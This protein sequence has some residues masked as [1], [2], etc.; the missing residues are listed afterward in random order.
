MST[1]HETTSLIRSLSVPD[2]LLE[3]QER[4]DAAHHVLTHKHMR[5][6]ALAI[7]GSY[8][9]HDDDTIR[10]YTERV[11]RELWSRFL[12]GAGLWDLMSSQERDR[13]RKVVGSEA[14]DPVEPFSAE[15]AL[16]VFQDLRERK[17]ELRKEA[18]AGLYRRLSWDHKT[19]QPAQF[20]EKLIY[21]G[22]WDWRGWE[23]SY[24]RDAMSDLMRELYRVDG[25]PEP[26]THWERAIDGYIDVQKFKNGNAHIRLLR[27]D[28]VDRLNAELGQW[29]PGALPAPSRAHGRGRKSEPRRH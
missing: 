9:I 6:F 14:R 1:T 15:T 18:L 13:W 5:D 16:G 24:G 2:L 4:L 28:L 21:Q 23:T 11:D 27:P 20:G 29:F 7:S 8:R 22:F 12:H 3:R 26:A 19:N 10:Y 25:K 17:D